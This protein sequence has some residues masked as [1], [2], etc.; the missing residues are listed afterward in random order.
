MPNSATPRKVALVLRLRTDLGRLIKAV[1]GPKKDRPEWWYPYVYADPR[2][3]EAIL[4]R[5][6]LFGSYTLRR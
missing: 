5:P 3:A 6:M 1:E 4:S 2:N